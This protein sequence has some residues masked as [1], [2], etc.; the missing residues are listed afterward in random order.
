M[1]KFDRLV[2]QHIQAM[3][4]YVAGKTLRQAEAESGIR[5]IKLASNENP[6]GPSPR[7]VEAIRRAAAEVNL[8]P[9]PDST[10]L[11][12]LL[13]TRHKLAPENIL[14]TAGSS[15]FLHMI[16]R[17]MLAPGLNAI[18]SEC[19]F[20][21]YPIIAQAAGA[22]L[23]K[24]PTR[25][26]GFDL[27]AILAAIDDDTRVILIA[28]PNNPTGSSLDVDAVT[29]FL[30]RVPSHVLVVLDEAYAD[31]AESFAAQRNEPY[32]HS[33]D[34]VREGR[35][36]V[37]LRTF[38]KVHGLAGLRMAY[39]VADPELI[40]YFARVKV[41]FSISSVGEAAA[42]AAIQDEA[43]IEKTLR[44]NL[45]GA[46]YLTENLTALGLRVLPTAANFV[47]VDVGEDSV[48]IARRLQ[49]EGVIVRPLAGWGAKNAI[50]VS[51]GTPEENE[52][53]IA[54]MKRLAPTV[55][56]RG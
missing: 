32:S 30:D 36:V 33:F 3:G 49:G 35:N 45:Q 50:R 15:S 44:N 6:F 5:C 17:T 39:G 29:R 38:S 51:I 14:V 42:L 19:S 23:V 4:R 43:H 9:E 40:Q 26:F 53:F 8:Y 56:V 27:D 34:Y 24:V 21:V 54:A 37:V 20:I 41:V 18:T 13:A 55:A 7:A 16:A 31:F 28:N 22:K 46:A 52:I 25:D 10:D 48:A 2:P 1:S 11:R 47:Y 12:Q